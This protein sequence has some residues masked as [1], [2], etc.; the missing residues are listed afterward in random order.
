MD[1]ILD[2]MRGI[3]TPIKSYLSR[4]VKTKK[5]KKK[6]RLKQIS[7]KTATLFFYVG[8][9]LIVFV[10]FISMFRA[11]TLAGNVSHLK[12]QVNE[13]S[14]TLSN[15][16]TNQLGLDVP[17]IDDYMK[18]FVEV[19]V[20]FNLDSAEERLTKLGDF[21][22]FE[23]TTFNEAIKGNR[24]LLDYELIAVDREDD[25]LLAKVEVSYEVTEGENRVEKTEILAVPLNFVS[26]KLAVVSPP[27]HLE[28]DNLLGKTEGFNQ[29]GVNEVSRLDD[30]TVNSLQKF[31]PLF[32]D[33]YASSN[34]TDLELLM[35]KPELMGKGY[36]VA[37]INDTSALF[38]RY[39][40]K[41]AVQITVE[42]ENV[43]TGAIHTEYFTL[44][45][46]KQKSG[47]FVNELYHYFK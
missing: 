45:L 37:T 42:F 35:A 34:R 2:K 13:V 26:D 10:A 22:A 29:K 41:K 3:V 23:E 32:F 47:W 33:K 43:E 1:K 38:Y 27:Y 8:V 18:Q 36:Q 46:T 6:A 21:Y 16:S 20:N 11:I 40:K 9:G 17:K 30:K 14:K 24:Q 25:Y 39:G 44:Y 5:P 31:L 15:Q 4:F 12:K 7:Q 28:A 19:Y